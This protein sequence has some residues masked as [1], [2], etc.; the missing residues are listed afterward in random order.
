MKELLKIKKKKV[1]DTFEN[2]IVSHPR[3]QNISET[4]IA[5]FNKIN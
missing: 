4:P 1:D 2:T 3:M 5:C